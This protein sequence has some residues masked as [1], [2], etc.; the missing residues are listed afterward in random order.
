MSTVEGGA[1]MFRRNEGRATQ[2]VDQA[3]SVKDALVDLANDKELRRRLAAAIDAGTAARRRVRSHVGLTGL[4]TG[5]RDD[6][7]LRA[8]LNELRRQVEAIQHRAK[9]RRSHKLRNATL[10]VGGAGIVSAVLVRLRND[11]PPA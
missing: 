5:L 10:V 4:A 8:E 7:V 2:I 9:R 6:S 3:S 1:V 11:S